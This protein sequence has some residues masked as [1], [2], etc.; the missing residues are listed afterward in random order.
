MEDYLIYSEGK[1]GILDSVSISALAILLQ[2]KFW[3]KG[4]QKKKL[5]S[6]LSQEDAQT[7]MVQRSQYLRSFSFHHKPYQ[8]LLSSSVLR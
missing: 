4:L 5:T 6:F 3:G 2:I 1:L 8:H 7:Y